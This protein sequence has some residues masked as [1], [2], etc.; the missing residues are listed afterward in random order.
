[1]GCVVQFRSERR[2]QRFQDA[3]LRCTAA[4]R[5]GRR[6]T[7]RLCSDEYRRCTAATY[8][9]GVL[10]A[11]ARAPHHRARLVRRGP[12]QGASNRTRGGHQGR[13]PHETASGLRVDRAFDWPFAEAARTASLA[14][15][16][17]L[18]RTETSTA[19]LREAAAKLNVG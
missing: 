5:P 1:M 7:P 19:D 9:P 16:N 6:R 2:G 13:L 18:Q 10:G 15:M 8:R 11:T 4:L 14:V 12:S 3:A 17:G